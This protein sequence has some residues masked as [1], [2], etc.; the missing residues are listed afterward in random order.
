MLNNKLR[1]SHSNV[2]PEGLGHLKSCSFGVADNHVTYA[3]V[4]AQIKQ[5]LPF[6]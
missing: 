5:G 2:E 1:G 3:F 4:N 6:E